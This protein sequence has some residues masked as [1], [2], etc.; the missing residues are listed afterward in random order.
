M[1]RT[2]TEGDR[3]DIRPAPNDADAQNC[4]RQGVVSLGFRHDCLWENPSLDEQ[5]SHDLRLC[6]RMTPQ[7]AGHHKPDVGAAL[8]KTMGMIHAASQDRTRLSVRPN[9]R[10]KDD[11]VIEAVA[12]RVPLARDR[13]YVIGLKNALDSRS[14]LYLAACPDHVRE[15]FDGRLRRSV[16]A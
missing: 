13:V 8:G 10:A 1:E 16:P 11:D 9:R 4:R 2:R 6:R 12:Q 7:T 14:L 5:I 3:P 15:L